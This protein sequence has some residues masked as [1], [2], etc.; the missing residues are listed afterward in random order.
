MPNQIPLGKR[1]LISRVDAFM[2]P[3]LCEV[4]ANRGAKII[5]NTERPSKF[6]LPG[7]T[8]I[9]VT[10]GRQTVPLRIPQSRRTAPAC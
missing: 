6:L 9:D 3:V 4:F 1:V 10:L 7:V 2:G 8:K 5:P